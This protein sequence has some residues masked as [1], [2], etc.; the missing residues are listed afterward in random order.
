MNHLL[1]IVF[2]TFIWIMLTLSFSITNLFTGFL[3]SYVV[4]WFIERK[5]KANNLITKPFK[6][7]V[8]LLFF[9][10]E[11]VVGSLR[12]AWD[13]ITP[14]HFM[15]PAILAIPLE[16]KTDWEITLLANSITL[17]PGTT[18]LAVSC[19]KSTLYIY[20]VYVDKSPQQTIDNIKNGLEKKL[21]EA[22]RL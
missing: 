1:I 11:V 19:D 15:T 3:V 5:D 7:I 20:T 6:I 18:S 9:A 12:L 21:L 10:K 17:T 4:V 14:T 13:I 22:L 16:A 8:Y 2:L